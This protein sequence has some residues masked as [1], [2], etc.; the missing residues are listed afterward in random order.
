MY[1]SD[2]LI[3]H[4]G[5]LPVSAKHFVY[6]GNCETYKVNRMHDLNLIPVYSG[7]FEKYDDIYQIGDFTEITEEGIYRISTEEGN[8][9][10]FIISN[11][12]YK[13]PARVLTNYF[14]WQRCADDLG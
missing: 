7:K 3:N 8:S 5:F 9:R 2:F 11:D 12:V 4:V 10:C 14:T 6:T 13:T 1:K